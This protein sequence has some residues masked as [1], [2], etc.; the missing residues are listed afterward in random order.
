MK[1]SRGKKLLAILLSAAM[2]LNMNVFSVSAQ[3]QISENEAISSNTVSEESVL[4]EVSQAVIPEVVSEDSISLITKTETEEEPVGAANTL[5]A[6][7]SGKKIYVSN[8]AVEITKDGSNNTIIKIGASV[9][10]YVD[11]LGAP[12]TITDIAEYTIIGGSYAESSVSE[13]SISMEN[14]VVKGIVG[15]EGSQSVSELNISINGGQVGTGGIVVASGTS[16]VKKASVTVKEAATVSTVTANTDT[17]VIDDYTTIIY[18]ND[19]MHVIGDKDDTSKN[20]NLIWYKNSSAASNLTEEKYSGKLFF[21]PSGTNT[22]GQVSG[23]FKLEET[24]SLPSTYNVVIGENESS[25]VP[26]PNAQ[27]F[28]IMSGVSL[29]NAGNID[30]IDHGTLEIKS[31]GVLANSGTTEVYLG[32]NVIATGD[33]ETGGSY[34]DII[35]KEI[36]YTSLPTITAPTSS[37]G[38]VNASAGAMEMVEQAAS[39]SA[40]TITGPSGESVA[41]GASIDPAVKPGRYSFEITYDIPAKMA[42]ESATKLLIRGTS[43]E[44][45]TGNMIPDKITVDNDANKLKVTYYRYVGTTSVT[46][47]YDLGGT[48]FDRVDLPYGSKGSALYNYIL[49]ATDVPV[50]SGY[51]FLGW[52]AIVNSTEYSIYDNDFAISDSIKTLYAKWETASKI[53]V[54]IKDVDDGTLVRTMS[55]YPDTLI[56][57]LDYDREFYE[58]DGSTVYKSQDT[59][60]GTWGSGVAVGTISENAPYLLYAKYTYKPNPIT[61]SEGSVFSVSFSKAPVT[62]SGEDLPV[63]CYTYTGREIRPKMVV[64]NGSLLLKENDDYVLTYTSNINTGTEATVTITGRGIYSGTIE[65]TFRIVPKSIKGVIISEIGSV[66]IGETLEADDIVVTDADLILAP[67]QYTVEFIAPLNSAGEEIEGSGRIKVR[68]AGLN[69]KEEAKV[70]VSKKVPVIN[71]TGKTDISTGFTIDTMQKQYTY[72]GKMVKPKVVLGNATIELVEGKD[73]KLSYQDNINVGTSAKVKAVGIGTYYGSLSDTFEITQ[74]E[75]RKVKIGSIPNV[76]YTGGTVSGLQL[77]VTDGQNVLVQDVDYTV[78]YDTGDGNKNISSGAIKAKV[79]I[80]AVKNSEGVYTGNYRGVKTATFSIV[81]RNLNNIYAVKVYRDDYN[82]VYEQ[83]GEAIKP[84][85]RLSYGGVML[86]EGVDYT[87]VYKN[88]INQGI[89]TVTLK[90]KNAYK[91]SRSFRFYII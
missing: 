71:K 84:V 65:K 81:K 28:V 77:K 25:L 69:Y 10:S 52:Y 7:T 2:I 24:L 20:S 48:Y 40:W 54:S 18:G 23:N 3:E 33:V 73:Y 39:A 17:G 49:S 76:T 38:V 78:T 62:V 37:T 45:L 86:V 12:T 82:L 14:G 5:V 88:N 8:N 19:V 79:T 53:Q 43:G 29:N 90:G 9:V 58:R 80:E 72:T 75:L 74:K 70:Y 27:S 16:Y 1:R 11:T 87:V 55:V 66:G 61:E 32:G 83:T 60:G 50:R 41:L 34:H 85:I 57:N 91:G 21:L 15:T 13:A 63:V 26:S 35:I 51:K 64:K 6:N 4:S 30:I 31:G 36:Q 89:G 42:C 46:L 56:G 67:D 44:T 22:A 59:E 47:R 68:G